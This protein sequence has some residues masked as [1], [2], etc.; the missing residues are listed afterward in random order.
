MQNEKKEKNKV[1]GIV[2]S[3]RRGGNTDLLVDEVLKGAKEIGAETEKIFLHKLK[4][5]PCDGC[6]VCFKNEKGN[7]KYEDDFEEVKQKME[8]N[9]TWI[10]GT[11]IYW[12]GPTAIT[13]AFI[14]RWYQHNITEQFFKDKNMILVVSSGGG[15]ESY[16]RHVVGMMEDIAKYVGINFKEKI[17]A[18]GVNKRGDVKNRPEILKK[19]INAGKNIS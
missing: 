14:D 8:E 17:I 11:P 16:S 5:N 7:C 3:P 18:T 15:S 10:I 6:N 13:K 12:W 19:A 4:I 2:G 1:L 9:D